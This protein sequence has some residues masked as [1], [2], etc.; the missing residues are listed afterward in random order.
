MVKWFSGK[1]YY[2]ISLNNEKKKN[3]K[4]KTNRVSALSLVYCIYYVF[5]ADFNG[6]YYNFMRQVLI[7]FERQPHHS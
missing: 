3:E 6:F 4:Q 7:I 1:N 5:R 2:T